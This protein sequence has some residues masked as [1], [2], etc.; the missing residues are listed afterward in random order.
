MHDDIRD[1][2]AERTGAIVLGRLTYD[3]FAGYWPHAKPYTEGEA[4]HPAEGREDPAII[5]ALNTL[6]KVVAS[7]T[8]KT[9]EW[10][11]TRIVHDGLE[12]EVL[13]LK[14]QPGKISISM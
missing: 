8:L 13:K 7:G 10:N 12:D 11:N 1:A 5:R 14:A 2:L 9:A 6:P 4:F 3:I